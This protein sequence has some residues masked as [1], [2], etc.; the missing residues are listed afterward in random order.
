MDDPGLDPVS[1]RA[2]LTGLARLNTASFSSGVL[3]RVIQREAACA[4]EPLRVLD[5]ACARGD[6]V[7]WA[8]A[9]AER[10]GVRACF[11]GC[12]I[13]AHAIGLATQAAASRGLACSFFTHDAVRE[14]LPGEYDVLVASLFLHHLSAA[15]GESLLRRMAGAARRAVIV[16]DLVRSRL[17]LGLVSVA[18]R[19]LTRS[20][21][22]HADAGLSVRA[23]LTR[24]ELL[25]MAERAGM[26]GATVTF[27]GLGRMML[28]HRRAV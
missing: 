22:V 20:P 23:A 24:R 16:N 8:A 18:S 5:I 3:W 4:A 6:W 10:S 26:G 13:N 19:L 14:S 28:V 1:L 27:G 25:A 7:L 15:D 12:D 9:K 11:A 21:I 17:N 2:A